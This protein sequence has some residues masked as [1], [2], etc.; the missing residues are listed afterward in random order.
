MLTAQQSLERGYDDARS[1]RP[2]AASAP[3]EP[4]AEPAGT[5]SAI[6]HSA[7]AGTAR[8]SASNEPRG[9]PGCGDAD[10]RLGLVFAGAAVRGRGAARAGRPMTRPS[11]TTPGRP[12][13]SPLARRPPPKLQVVGSRSRPQ[14]WSRRRRRTGPASLSPRAPIPGRQ[15]QKTRP[16][17]RL[18]SSRA[19]LSSCADGRPAPPTGESMQIAATSEATRERSARAAQR[20]SNANGTTFPCRSAA[21]SST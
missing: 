14:R 19:E 11:R 21:R 3:N 16:Q 17:R 20:S 13:P 12:A 15:E 9:L 7:S 1:S 4:G 5:A 18:S 2:R 10:E 8:W 6:A